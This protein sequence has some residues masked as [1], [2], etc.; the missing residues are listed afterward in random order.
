MRGAITEG[1][2]V[3]RNPIRGI[4]VGCCASAEKPRAKSTEHRARKK[5]FLGIAFY[6]SFMLMTI[7]DLRLLTSDLRYL[8]TLS[9]LASTLGG[10]VRPIC[11]AVFR[12]ITSSIFVGCST[13]RSAGLAP[14]MILST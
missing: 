6:P 7:A 3:M 12:L 2:E 1:E 11:L 10:I 8:I 14:F 5:I 13:G 9:A 4:V